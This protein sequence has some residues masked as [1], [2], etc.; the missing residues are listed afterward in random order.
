LKEDPA[1]VLPPV[2]QGARVLSVEQLAFSY[3]AN[4]QGQAPS[5]GLKSKLGLHMREAGFHNRLVKVDGKPHRLWVIDA[6]LNEVESMEL[7][8]E[9]RKI[10]GKV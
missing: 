8:K 3:M 7:A 4:E 9:W 1:L 6:Q 5:Q 10:R 2:L